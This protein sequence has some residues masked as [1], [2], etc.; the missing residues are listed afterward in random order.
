MVCLALQAEIYRCKL[1][2]RDFY[3]DAYIMNYVLHNASVH[4]Y[5]CHSDRRLHLTTLQ[6]PTEAGVMTGNSVPK[7]VSYW[8]WLLTASDNCPKAA[9]SYVICPSGNSMNHFCTGFP[10]G[11][12]QFIFRGCVRSLSSL[13]PTVFT[14]F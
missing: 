7:V 10:V 6:C 8:V 13:H 2:E 14:G 11:W 12:P 3:K 9:T 4:Y 5:P 1:K